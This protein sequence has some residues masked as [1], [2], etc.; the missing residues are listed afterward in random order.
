MMNCIACPAGTVPKTNTTTNATES[1][2]P[3]GPGTYRTT[4]DIRLVDGRAGK[5]Q[6][7]GHE[8]G[9]V[10]AA[11][12]KKGCYCRRWLGPLDSALFS[13]SSRPPVHLIDG[14][15]V[16]VVAICAWLIQLPTCP[17]F[18]SATCLP[19]GAGMEAG[20]TANQDCTSWWVGG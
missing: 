17:L 1:C 2:T 7:G 12:A 3:C 13:S 6:T 15:R 5:Q 18:C 20:A 19:C 11:Y 16:S 8:S 10:G 14:F 4:N 9:W